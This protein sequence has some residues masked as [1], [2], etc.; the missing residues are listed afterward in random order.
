MLLCAITAVL[1]QPTSSL[2]EKWRKWKNHHGKVYADDASESARRSTWEDNYKLVAKHNRNSSIHGF[3]LALNQFADL[4][5]LYY[6]LLVI[7]IN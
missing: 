5:S 7:S 1:V 4:V 2:H 3:T 6:K